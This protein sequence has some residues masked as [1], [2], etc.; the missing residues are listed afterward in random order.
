MAYLVNAG[1]QLGALG[2]VD[3]II[4][5]NNVLF[6][7]LACSASDVEDSRCLEIK[8]RGAELLAPSFPAR[9][10]HT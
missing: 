4:M 1:A 7:G 2:G 6:I 9:T 8:T 5:V 3:F 10:T